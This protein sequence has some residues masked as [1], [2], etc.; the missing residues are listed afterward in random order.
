M[1]T[2]LTKPRENSIRK[3][4]VVAQ[5]SQQM[6][7]D[8]REK[9][10]AL[11]PK[12]DLTK[13]A[14]FVLSNFLEAKEHKQTNGVT[15]RLIACSRQR[16]GE[17]EP[18]VLSSIRE[19]QGT[20]LFFNITESKCG[21]AEAWMKDLIS[22]TD[23]K[24][25][26]LEPTPIPGL[27]MAEE[28]QIQ[29]QVMM[30]AEQMGAESQ[31]DVANI[32]D[33]VYDE[34]LHERREVAKK[35]CKRMEDTIQDQLVEG[36][37]A[38]VL[39]D[40]IYQYCTFPTAF[41]KGPILQIQKKLVWENSVAQIKDQHV[42]TW[43]A[44]D[45]KDIYP[46]PNSQ[47]I[48]DSY[49]CQ[50]VPMTKSALMGM[51]DKAGWSTEGIN[52]AI[53]EGDMGNPA[54]YGYGESERALLENRETGEH[55]GNA[56]NVMRGVEYWGEIEGKVLKEAGTNLG[57]PDGG[58]V[59][60]DELH[61]VTVLVF[62]S[63]VVRAVLNPNPTGEKPYYAASHERVPG[64][65]W[66]KALPEKIAHCQKSF[67]AAMRI[68]IDNMAL[69][70]GPMAMIDANAIDAGV[71]VTTIAPRKAYYYDSDKVRP[72]SGK[73]VEFFQPDSNTGE[74]LQAASTFQNEADNVSGIPR[75]AHGDGG[76]Q[77]A[78]ET[79][80]G[81]AML[82]NNASKGIKN[83]LL[84]LDKNII[85]PAIR[86]SYLWNMLHHED[87]SIKGDVHLKARGVIG[88]LVKEQ[89]QMQQQEFMNLANNPVDNEIIG[90][91]GRRKM[92]E[93]VA[94]RLGLV[95]VVPDEDTFNQQE[96]MRQ[97]EAMRM[98]EQEQEMAMMEMEAQAQGQKA[99]AN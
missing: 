8:Q 56:P 42:L 90:K 12:I 11:K 75:F 16:T 57:L 10:E 91:E 99:G 50:I 23:G 30:E 64:S 60:D 61:P 7:E 44:P 45:P 34:Q 93:D 40:F 21:D 26:S 88:A 86:Q 15:D 84:A 67:N 36:R 22:P 33:S 98:Q 59:G 32:L 6:D 39:D 19:G 9:E 96:A 28:A 92:L 72:G 53:A 46:A 49:M 65:L 55:S 18:E 20:E 1:E 37:F 27:P 74:L 51:R 89:Q 13:L 79:S 3:G 83:L 14:D 97:E 4:M 94:T 76:V 85:R 81:L 47:N 2:G 66:G 38:D 82:M 35:K 58:E 73:V 52:A 41:L 80:S 69:A 77:G 70:S 43:S 71:D 87:S 5:S 24:P 25:W 63:N 29:Q 68:L 31:A 48:N 95:D 17:Y 78:G 62:G 54:D